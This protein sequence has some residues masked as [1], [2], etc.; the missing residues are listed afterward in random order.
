MTN[1]KSDLKLLI[2][3]VVWMLIPSI[4]LLVRMN[5]VSVNNVDINILGQMEWFDLMDEVITTML[6]V[7]LYSLLSKEKSKYMNGI[8]FLTSVLIYLFFTIM[9]VRHITGITRFMNAEYAKEYLLLQSISLVFSFVLTFVVLLLTINS[10]HKLVWILIIVKVIMLSICD[11]ILIGKYKDIGAAY[12]EILVNVLLSVVSICLVICKGYIG[13]KRTELSFFNEWFQIGKFAG[14]QIFLDNFIYAIM[15]VK[16]VNAVNEAGNYWVANNFIWGWLLVPVNCF[17]ELIKKNNLPSISFKNTWRYGLMIVG[18]WVITMPFWSI[19]IN[20][21]MAVDSN[22][23]MPIVMLNMPFYI[24]YIVSAFLDA[25][26][27]SKGKTVYNMIISL[28]VNIVY[29]G[30]IYILFK[31]GVFTMNMNFIIYMFG[32]GMV[33]HMILTMVFYAV[34]CIN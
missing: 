26:F 13:L 29:Y 32:G 12:S 5:I 27:I 10:D 22:V 21:A 20:K 25:W 33:V 31:N 16:M 11:S 28:I 34:E 30:I 19:F 17:S 9:I 3:L 14:I 24:T 2:S 15:I 6:I 8:A 1:I 4:Y 18:L 23:I 7:P